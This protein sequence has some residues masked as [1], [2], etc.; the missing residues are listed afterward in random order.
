[1]IDIRRSPKESKLSMALLRSLYHKENQ[2]GSK[3]PARWRGYLLPVCITLD[4]AQ[5]FDVIVYRLNLT[6]HYR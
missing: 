1:M 3:Y 4:A 5:V 2:T 6:G